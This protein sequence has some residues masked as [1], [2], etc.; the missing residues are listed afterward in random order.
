ME[1]VEQGSDPAPSTA[2][3]AFLVCRCAILIAM[4]FEKGR[5]ELP[6]LDTHESLV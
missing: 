4:V 3:I 1:E 6:L 2:T 5:Q